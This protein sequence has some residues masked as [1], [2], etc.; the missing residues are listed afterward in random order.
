MHSVCSAN[1]T[2]PKSFEVHSA[3][4]SLSQI[5]NETQYHKS[6]THFG[7]LRLQHSTG[8]KEGPPCLWGWAHKLSF[9]F[10]YL[11]FFI[12]SSSMLFHH[13]PSSIKININ[14]SL[15]ISLSLS[16]LL[17]TQPLSP[18]FSASLFKKMSL[19]NTHIHTRVHLCTLACTLCTQF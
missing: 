3:Y 16:A 15:P 6:L 13:F 5:F 19:L 7:I 4:W 10:L 17:L 8:H 11:W 18:G 1:I 14:H 9:A 2:S 12:P